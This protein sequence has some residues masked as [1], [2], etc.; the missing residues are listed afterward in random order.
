MTRRGALVR[1]VVARWTAVSSVRLATIGVVVVLAAACAPATI[2]RDF[3]IAAVQRIKVGV[4]T[5][6]EVRH[7]FG[8]PTGR[9][10]GDRVA[11]V[12]TFSFAIDDVQTKA[13]SVTFRGDVV[14]ECSLT[15]R[16]ADGNADSGRPAPPDTVPC[17]D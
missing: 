2:G 11:E 16:R 15:V 6:S 1:D 7:I 10:V 13:L 8:E 12:W 4:T 17:G 3:D 9:H 14:T 5:S